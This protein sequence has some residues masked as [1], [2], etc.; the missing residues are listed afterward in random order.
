MV[1]ENSRYQAGYTVSVECCFMSQMMW[2]CFL[3][4]K[5]TI[6]CE[7]CD[8]KGFYLDMLGTSGKITPNPRN[9][10]RCPQLS[11]GGG[12]HLSMK[13]ETKIKIKM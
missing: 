8:C 2:C 12:E 9:N 13:D 5:K 10:E 4:V 6:I 3:I 1:E 7:H 11:K